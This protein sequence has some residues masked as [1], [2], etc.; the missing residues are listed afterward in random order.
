MHACTVPRKMRGYHRLKT[1]YVSSFCL[2]TG[3]TLYG[4]VTVFT[5]SDDAWRRQKSRGL[6]KMKTQRH[7][8]Y[9]VCR[10]ALSAMRAL[11]AK[12]AK[13]AGMWGWGGK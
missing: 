13:K 7:A 5:A 9:L 1:I 3:H 8:V 6:R 12:A 4:V 11:K 2:T 10:L